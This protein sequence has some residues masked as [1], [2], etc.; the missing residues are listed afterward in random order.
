MLSYDMISSV[1]KIRDIKC[2]L[3]EEMRGKGVLFEKKKNVQK[4]PVLKCKHVG[5]FFFL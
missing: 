5:V 4:T 1:M 2:V 3:V